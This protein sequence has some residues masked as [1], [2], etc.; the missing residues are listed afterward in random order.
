MR[1]LCVKGVLGTDLYLQ[2]MDTNINEVYKILLN[3]SVSLINAT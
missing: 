3:E 1:H 2:Y